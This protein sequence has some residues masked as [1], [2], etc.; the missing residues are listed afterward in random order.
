MLPWLLG[1]LVVVTVIVWKVIHSAEAD[2]KLRKRSR[3]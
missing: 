1:G 2:D 3:R